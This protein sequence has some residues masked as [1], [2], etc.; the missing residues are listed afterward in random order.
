ML[1][2]IVEGPGSTGKGR[3]RCKEVTS[4]VRCVGRESIDGGY[5]FGV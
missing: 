4:E 1:G 3:I 2:E 5:K